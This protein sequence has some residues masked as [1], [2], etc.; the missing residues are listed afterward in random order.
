MTEFVQI[1]LLTAYPP[2]NLNR[3]DLG[4]PK[5]AYMGGIERLRISSQCIKRAIRTS[6]VFAQDLTDPHGVATRCVPEYVKSRLES[7][8]IDAEVIFNFIQELH[9]ANFAPKDDKKS[10]KKAKKS[11]AFDKKDPEGSFKKLLDKLR[12]EAKET[13]RYS[14]FELQHLDHLCDQ[15]AQDPMH[16]FNDEELRIL[17]F[18]KRSV[19]IA[20]FGRMYA[21]SPAYNVEAAC[22]I[23]HPISVNPGVV[24]ADFFTAVDDLANNYDQTD[25]SILGNTL[26]GA[27][28]YY[29]YACVDVDL[30][31]KNLD[32]NAELAQKAIRNL[33]KALATVSPSGHQNSF[34][35]RAFADFVLVERGTQAPRSLVG[36]FY[37]PI[38]SANQMGDAVKALRTFKTKLDA[39]YGSK[40]EA[41]ASFCIDE[42]DGTLEDVVRLTIQ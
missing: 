14:H 16:K 30:L 33:I 6:S 39:A 15:L 4:R 23:S 41:E 13:V 35:S 2:S 26:F 32:G 7:K 11:L 8:Q 22:Q 17:Q 28:V 24:E 36:A 34:A 5:T 40:P 29:T 9:G 37:K 27:A 38:R 20:M 3:D 25:A 18:E 31:T 42:S 21:R 1:H 12:G 19:D 10:D